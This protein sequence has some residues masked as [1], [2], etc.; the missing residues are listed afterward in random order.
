M[1]K[2]GNGTLQPICIRFLVIEKELYC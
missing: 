2:R 1:E